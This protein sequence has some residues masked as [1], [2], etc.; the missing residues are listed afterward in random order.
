V[1]RLLPIILMLALVVPVS[2]LTSM[3]GRPVS[4][5]AAE[6]IAPPPL[7]NRYIV[8]L[9]DDLVGAAEVADE[10]SVADTRIKVSQV[11]TSA[12]NGFAAEI[13]ADELV[14]LANDPRVVSIEP[15]RPIYPQA[16]TLPKGADRIDADR[17]ELA[18]IDGIDGP[19]ERVDAD[20]AILD[21]GVG[22]HSDL[23]VVGGYDCT[24]YGFLTDNGG[25]GTHVAGI[26]G[27]IDNGKGI[28]GVAPGVRLWSVRVLDAF[29][30]SWS[31]VI[32]GLDWV[33]AHADTIEVANMSLGEPYGPDPTCGSTALHRAVCNTVNAG[34]TVVVAAGNFWPNGTNARNGVPAQYKEVI[35]VSAIADS[36]GKPGGLGPAT[37]DGLDDHRANFSAYGEVVDIAAPGVDTYSTAP[38]G[39][40]SVMSGTS[41]ATP[42]VAGAAALYIAK[43]GRVGP[44]AVRA[45]L[46]AEREKVHIPGDPDGIDEG[47]VNVGDLARGSLTLAK[48]AGKPRDVVGFT[49]SNFKKQ[50]QVTLQWDSATLLTVT[51]NASGAASGTIKIPPTTKG[52]HTVLATGNGRTASAPFTVSPLLL[53]SPTSGAAYREATI[54]LRGYGRYEEVTVKF[55]NGSRAATLANVKV[56]RHGSADVDVKLPPAFTGKHRIEGTGSFGSE[57]TA[58]YTVKPSLSFRPTAAEP[59]DTFTATLRGLAASSK[60]ELRWYEGAAAEVIGTGQTSTAG[61]VVIT[62]SVPENAASGKHRVE[63]VD[64]AG[65]LVAATF[66]VRTSVASTAEDA[67]TPTRE[68]TPDSTAE[69]TPEPT[70]DVTAPYRISRGTHSPGSSSARTVAD[71]DP[72]TVWYATGG[73]AP[74]AFVQIDLGRTR[75]IGDIRWLVAD[76]AAIAGLEIQVSTD[77]RTWTTLATPDAGP[78]GEWQSASAATEARYIRFAF[79]SA[80]DGATVGGIA[81]IEIRP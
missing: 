5:A 34:V 75:P 78:A 30:G 40:S 16:Q 42:H 17:N 47:I 66:T 33:T 6:V 57:A 22:P 13:P 9:R 68:P 31:W 71:G 27:A 26:A 59:G 24:G 39:G 19:G 49:L 80:A 11:Y 53:V 21:M 2:Q 50:S 45:G 25:H 20:I 67:P 79:P 43:H 62:V 44:A 54:T 73:E 32:C 60:V 3:A 38:G 37:S 10:F 41:F 23:N 74:L 14:T 15:D 8:V 28:V 69:P 61:T 48:S 56:S 52:L 12:L 1:L 4:A 35:T 51:T 76:S 58:T 65:T 77:R 36:D 46:L 7:N 70:G 18:K 64:T 63:G 81:E 29:A 55:F 72:T